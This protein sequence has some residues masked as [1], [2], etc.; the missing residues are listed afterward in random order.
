M[1]KGIRV[2][3][4]EFEG[5]VYVWEV[6][7]SDE[8]SLQYKGPSIQGCTRHSLQVQKVWEQVCLR[9]SILVLMLLRWPSVVSEGTTLFGLSCLVHCRSYQ[10][11]YS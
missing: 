10:C 2:C 3:W 1:R 11:S 5:E 9:D 8:S 7:E 6:N 4:N